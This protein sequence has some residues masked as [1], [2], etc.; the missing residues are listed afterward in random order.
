LFRFI[1]YEKALC[2][3]LA[4]DVVN[5]LTIVFYAALLFECLYHHLLQL[6]DQRCPAPPSQPKAARRHGIRRALLPGPSDLHGGSSAHSKATL[7]GKAV[8]LDK[9]IEEFDEL[10]TH[11]LESLSIAGDRFSRMQQRLWGR[12]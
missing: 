6:R 11:L 4:T 8:D 1:L 3:D 2:S 5:A 7:S 10:A 12:R 9:S